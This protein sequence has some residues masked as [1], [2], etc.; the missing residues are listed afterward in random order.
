M[1][2]YAADEYLCLLSTELSVGHG[3]ARPVA[4]PSGGD[5]Q[6]GPATGGAPVCAGETT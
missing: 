5:H 4:V 1:L 6:P 3:A 2:Y